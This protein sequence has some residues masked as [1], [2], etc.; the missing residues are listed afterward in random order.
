MAL[1]TKDVIGSPITVLPFDEYMALM[2][3][4]ANNHESRITC[5]ANVHM[6][7]EAY[8]N[9]TFA[10]VLQNADLVTPDG[11]PLV[12]MLRCMGAPQQTRVAG[13]DIFLALC[14]L[15]PLHD[16]KI[17]FVGS[18]AAILQRIR[19]RL[20]QQFPCLTIAG[21]E[22][23]PFRPLT[24]VEDEALIEKIH[25]SGAGLVL[26][27]LGCPKQ[28]YWMAQH[29]GKI[30]AVLVGVG[31]V[32]PVYAGIQKWAPVWV[33]QWGLEWFYRLIQEPR[34]LWNRY[35]TTIPPFIYLALRQ[36][37]MA[38]LKSMPIN[39][40]REQPPQSSI[41]HE[42]SLI[43]NSTNG[44]DQKAPTLSSHL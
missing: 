33:R 21:M 43:V 2:L 23:L 24:P 32:F 14:Q 27:A 28:E 13:M 3:Q 18:Q 9:P 31:G 30:Q 42:Q 36:L 11:M 10:T 26:I 22:P 25:Q 34:R 29:Q 38:R 37:L 20:E 6:L 4:W 16:V 39:P 19:S 8:W 1:L 44:E 17:F 12:W 7:M 5:V 41:A 15:A 40:D 35:S